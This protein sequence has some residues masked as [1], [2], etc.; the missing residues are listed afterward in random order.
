MKRKSLDELFNNLHITLNNN[1]KSK[2]EYEDEKI[3]TQTEVDDLLKS[4]QDFLLN[5]FNKY[6]KEMRRTTDLKTPCWTY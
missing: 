4:Q 1:K 3:Y 6:I 2:T 5:E